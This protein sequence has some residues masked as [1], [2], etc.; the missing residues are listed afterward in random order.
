MMANTVYSSMM[1]TGAAI[2]LVRVSARIQ[3]ERPDGPE[4]LNRAGAKKCNF[5]KEILPARVI[6][7]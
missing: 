3:L 7:Y 4:S 1:G 2:V 6:Q 5:E